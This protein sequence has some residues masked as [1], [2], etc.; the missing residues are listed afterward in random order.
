MPMANDR[1][2]FCYTIGMSV[3]DESTARNLAR[4]S[5]VLITPNQTSACKERHLDASTSRA[6][7]GGICAS[8]GE[9][10][11]QWTCGS[12]TLVTAKM[13]HLLE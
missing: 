13:Q 1:I 10:L 5:S 6:Y 7:S 4:A 2:Q 11:H 8:E 9:Y 3:A 12:V